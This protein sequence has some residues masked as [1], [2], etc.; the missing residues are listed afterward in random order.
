MGTTRKSAR[1]AK[2]PGPKKSQNPG[3]ITQDP[4]ECSPDL[5][6]LERERYEEGVDRKMHRLADTLGVTLNTIFN[7]YDSPDEILRSNLETLAKLEI[8]MAVKKRKAKTGLR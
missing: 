3:A 4:L 1:K 2:K 5:E 8:M 7:P 6:E